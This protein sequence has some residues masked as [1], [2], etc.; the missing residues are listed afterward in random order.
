MEIT[1]A[2]TTRTMPQLI[3]TVNTL[4]AKAALY[5]DKS[6]QMQIT[7]GRT[8]EEAK[9]LNKEA[10]GPPWAVFVKMNF[11]FG[12]SRA[13]ELIRIADGRTNVATVREETAK[14]V[15]KHAKAKPALANAGSPSRSNAPAIAKQRL[16]HCGNASD[17]GDTNEDIA[18]RSFIG[19]AKDS[20][21]MAHYDRTD[22]IVTDDI[23]RFAE[24]AADSWTRLF[25][26]LKQENGNR[27]GD[28]GVTMRPGR[29]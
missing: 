29:S 12:Q 6:E 25:G 9:A 4:H 22:L 28:T 5:A 27:S 3:N 16:E 20:S 7:I 23:L 18:K 21:A 10:S 8:L 26:E 19:R 11:K 15:Q 2:T 1:M 13:D 24:D 17:L 14:R